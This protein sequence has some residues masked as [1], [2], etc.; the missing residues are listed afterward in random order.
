MASF[1]CSIWTLSCCTWDLVP[2]P[3]IEHS[4]PALGAWSLSHW[5]TRE[6]PL[7]PLLTSLPALIVRLPSFLFSAWNSCVAHALKVVKYHVPLTTSL[8]KKLLARK[9]SLTREKSPEGEKRNLKGGR[10]TCR[11]I[12]KTTQR[13]MSFRFVHMHLSSCLHWLDIFSWAC[14]NFF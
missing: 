3:G 12:E 6:V 1:R 10:K 14:S 11:K 5:T 9:V 4:P 7:S 2:R 13:S 8:N